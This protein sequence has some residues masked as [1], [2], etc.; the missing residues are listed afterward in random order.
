MLTLIVSASATILFWALH[1]GGQ[2]MRGGTELGR[3]RGLGSAHEGAHHWWGQRM[4]AAGEPVA[5]GLV[6]GLDRAAA[7]V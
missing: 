1:A 5:D 3:V 7:G 6:D 4:T 2:V